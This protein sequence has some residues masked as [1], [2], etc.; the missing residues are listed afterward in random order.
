MPR[1]GD[2]TSREATVAARDRERQVL[3]LYIRGVNFVQIGRQLG[4]EESTA[5]KA[6][7]RMVNPTPPI[8]RNPREYRAAQYDR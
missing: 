5:R 4:V 1:G 6:F 2:H 8:R 3:S 7:N